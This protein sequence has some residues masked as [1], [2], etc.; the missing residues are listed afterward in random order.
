MHVFRVKYLST[1]AIMSQKEKNTPLA[2]LTLASKSNTLD[3]S[4]SLIPA[5]D[6]LKKIILPVFVALLAL[7]VVYALAILFQIHQEMAVLQSAVNTLSSN[8]SSVQEG[9]HHDI[10]S[11]N[12]SLSDTKNLILAE[13]S[14]YVNAVEYS[15]PRIVQIYSTNGNISNTDRAQVSQKLNTG[16]SVFSTGT[17]FF[18]SPDGYIVTAGHVIGDADTVYILYNHDVLLTSNQEVIPVAASLILQAKVIRYSKDLDM[19]L[20]KIDVPFPVNLTR[21]INNV[22]VVEERPINA[23]PYFKL[24][25][26]T[27]ASEG[28]DFL[29]IG[30]PLNVNFPVNQKGI[31]SAKGGLFNGKNSIYIQ[32]L[33]NP[34]NSGGPVIDINTNKVVGVVLQRTTINLENEKLRLP[35]LETLPQNESSGVLLFFTIYN[36]LLDKIGENSPLGIGIAISSDYIPQLLGAS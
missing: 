32:T 6:K 33:V 24:G 5:S 30:Y 20:L 23:V 11:I 12:S 8:F 17:G 2:N 14:S 31:V 29:V 4:S 34:G 13:E 28:Q 3:S 22:S 9:I 25:D 36:N 21:Q 10:D 26:F 27:S 1:T 15:K 7:L 16:E 19:A 35:G 18:V